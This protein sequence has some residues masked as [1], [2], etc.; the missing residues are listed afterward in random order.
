MAK[1][2]KRQK[3][4]S[5]REL[6]E[7]CTRELRSLNQRYE[8]LFR[9]VHDSKTYAPG[10]LADNLISV[11]IDRDMRIGETLNVRIPFK[12]ELR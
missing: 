11:T 5:A 10:S 1:K 7:Q 4:P 12:W 2:K 6:F 3:A 8:S 9:F